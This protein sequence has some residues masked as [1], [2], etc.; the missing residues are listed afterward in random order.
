MGVQQFLSKLL[1]RNS[2]GREVDL[3]YFDEIVVVTTTPNEPSSSSSTPSTSAAANTTNSSRRGRPREK[4]RRLRI[5]LDVSSWIHRAC[6]GFGDLLADERHLDNYGRAQLL[7]EQRQEQ[8]RQQQQQAHEQ[9][10]VQPDQQ[11]RREISKEQLHK[12]T[13]SCTDYVL[14]RVQRLSQVANVL[15]VLDGIAPPIK[16]VEIQKRRDKRRQAVQQRD[17][18]VV[19]QPTVEAN[20]NT[21]KNNKNQDAAEIALARR[22]KAFRR[23][24][25]G[26]HYPHVIDALIVTLRSSQVPFLVAPYE[27]DGQLAFLSE[28]R[29]VDLIVT[30]DSDLV[31]C[32]ASPILYK[33]MDP[34]PLSASSSSANQRSAPEQLDNDDK[35]AAFFRGQLIRKEDLAAT[36]DLNLMDFSPAMLATLFVAA[37]SDYC[38]SLPGIGIKTANAIVRKA[39]ERPTPPASGHRKDSHDANQPS[40]SKVTTSTSTNS[41]LKQV[42]NQLYMQSRNKE[43][44]TAEFK[45]SFEHNFLAAIIMFRHPVVFHPL[46]GKCIVRNLDHP[47]PELMSYP[48]YAA[49]VNSSDCIHAIV[50]TVPSAPLACHVA[51]GWIQLQTQL[52][53][54]GGGGGGG[55]DNDDDRV[56]LPRH[57]RQFL[58]SATGV[59]RGGRLNPNGGGVAVEA[60][61]EDIDEYEHEDDDDEEDDDRFETQQEDI[62]Q[63]HGN[64]LAATMDSRQEEEEEGLLETQQ[65]DRLETQPPMDVPARPSLYVATATAAQLEMET[66]PQYESQAESLALPARMHSTPTKPSCDSILPPAK[67]PRQSNQNDSLDTQATE[68]SQETQSRIPATQENRF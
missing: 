51:E 30:E 10:Q 38:P 26:K 24:G 58:S 43:D 34:R 50:G 4:Q 55:D 59:E 32:G 27:A 13:H 39:F 67:R 6:Q 60:A 5:A 17:A 52:P 41:P 42:L 22:L 28:Q 2:A 61:Y 36:R 11:P 68:E 9:N 66:Q 65:L 64:N 57:V 49:I 23:A 56:V 54:G 29:L 47:D 48:P 21:D 3:R 63:Q 37:G 35:E 25:A 12:F 14:R 62:L 19:L 40:N 45:Q 33:I 46:L 7:Q 20:N 44:L 31:A 1:E 16:K 18:P 15:V 53:R 8:Q